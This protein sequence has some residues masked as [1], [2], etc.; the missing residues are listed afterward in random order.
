MNRIKSAMSRAMSLVIAVLLL[1]IQA[2]KPSEN[3]KTASVTEASEAVPLRY[4]KLFTM[5][6]ENGCTWIDVF[7]GE[8]NRPAPVA[9]YLLVPRG[10]AVPEHDADMLVVETPVRRLTCDNGLELSFLDLLGASEALAGVSGK[11]LISHDRIHRAIDD[12]TLTV[13]GYGRSTNM[14]KLLALKPDVTFIT[15]SFGADLPSRLRSY[16]MTPGLFS[17]YHEEHPLGVVEWIRFMGAF[18]G[19]E[20]LA[21]AIFREKES[22]YLTM[23]HKVRQV[24]ERPAVIAGYMSK[25]AW[26]TMNAPRSFVTMLDHAGSDY[27]FAGLEPERGYLLSGEVAVQAGQRAAFW[28]NTHSQASTLQQ[29]LVEDARYAGFRSV[30]EGR[31]YNNNG[32]CFKNGKTEYWDIGMTEPDQILADLVAIFHPELMPG[33]KLRY[34]QRLE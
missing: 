1:S 12:G 10:K 8:K 30:R 28:L 18:L 7:A 29:V 11:V 17:A 19:K 3:A 13:T 25:G 14:E 27:L 4:A 15:T 9:R 20:S 34:Y 32:S 16:G 5:K 24:R 33:H 23:Q 26:S 31:V 2:C 6:R 21:E 22:A